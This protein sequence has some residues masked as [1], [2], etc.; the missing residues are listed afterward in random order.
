MFGL[1]LAWIVWLIIDID[2]LE[3]SVRGEGSCRTAG[4]QLRYDKHVTVAYGEF[5]EELRKKEA[6]KFK[7]VA[8]EAE[9]EAEAAAA[10]MSPPPPPLP[11]DGLVSAP[12]VAPDDGFATAAPPPIRFGK[13]RITT[14]RTPTARAP[15]REKRKPP[16]PGLRRRL[17][18]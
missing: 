17:V 18:W 7:D 11:E 10:A 5:I 2:L 1:H 15:E 8:V 12:P 13:Y 3:S 14:P 16:P 9:A 6:N 4:E